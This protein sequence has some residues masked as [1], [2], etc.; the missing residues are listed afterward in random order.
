MAQAA[1]KKPRSKASKAKARRR[2]VRRAIVYALRGLGVAVAL[3][4]GLVLLYRFV[5]PP[6]THTIWSEA[7]R[8]GGVD[9]QWVNIDEV[10][11]SAVRAVVAAEDAN[12]CTHWGF[13]MAAI[14]QAI[15]EGANRGASTLTQ[16]AVKN[17][18]LWQERSWARKALEALM[19]PLVEAMWPKRRVLEVYLNVAEFGEGIFG[20]DAAAHHY[21]RVTPGALTP[22]QGARLAVI[23][24]SPKQRDAANLPAWLRKRAAQV[25]DGA[26]TI[27]ADGRASCFES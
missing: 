17:V 7:R 22:A 23:L 13:D 8:L 27:K 18:F 19:T 1:K 2:P 16:Q 3:V 6:M 24:P 14:R 21:F 20:I 5:N 26:A 4:V 9:Q 15:D 10:A 25:Q 11:P 12:F